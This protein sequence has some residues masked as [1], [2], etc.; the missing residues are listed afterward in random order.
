[1]KLKKLAFALLL[2]FLCFLTTSIYAQNVGI[3]STGAAPDNSAMLD[4]TSTDKG[5]L[6]P[7]MTTTQ[8]DAISNPATG[9]MIYNS[10]DNQFNFYDG[11]AWSAIGSGSGGDNLGNHTATQDVQLN[12]NWL[13]NDGGALDY[14][15]IQ[16]DTNG[17]VGIQINPAGAFQVGAGKNAE[18]L[19]VNQSNNLNANNT[20]PYWQ[21]FTAPSDFFLTR[22]DIV[23]FNGTPNFTYSLYEGEGTGGTLL[24]TGTSTTSSFTFDEIPLLA[25]QKYTINIS[26]PNFSVQIRQANVDAYS[27]GTSNAIGG[28]DLTFSVYGRTSRSGLLVS[29]TGVAFENYAFPVADGTSN[30]V[31]STNGTG[32]VSWSNQPFSNFT[33][34]G[35]D[36]TANQVLT[37]DG[38]GTIS[39]T[40]NNTSIL[41]DADQNTKIQVEK[42]SNED[43]I[44]FDLNGEEKWTMQGNRLSN[45]Q[46]NIYIGKGTGQQVTSGT[47]IIAIG[48]STLFSNTSGIGNIAVGE[49]SLFANTTG[50]FNIV[51]GEYALT[52]NTIGSNNIAM[53]SNALLNCTSGVRNVGLGR[54]AGSFLT[55]GS[56][57]TLLGYEVGRTITTGSENVMLGMNA[58]LNAGN[59]TGSTLV[60]FRAGF[61]GNTQVTAVGYQAGSSSGARGVYLGYNAGVNETGADKLYIDNSATTTPLIWGDFAND[62]LKVFGTFNINDAFNFPTTDG[63]NGQ[64][65][66]TDGAG[67]LTWTSLTSGGFQD[68]SLSGNTLSL[69][70]DP[71]TV[72]LSSFL[73]NTDQQDLS[74][75]NDTLTISNGTAKI[76]L[77]PYLAVDDLGNHIATQNIQLNDQWISNDGG[78]EGFIINND[79]EIG[80][81]R[82]VG[83]N[84]G[85]KLELYGPASSGAGPHIQAVTSTSDHPV[86]QYFNFDHDNAAILFD[87]YYNPATPSWKSSDAGS[88]FAI[89]KTVDKLINFYSAGNAPGNDLAWSTGTFLDTLGNF[90][91][92]RPLTTALTNRLEV[93][94]QAS[95]T[96]AGSWIA[97]SDARLKK[98][99]ISLSANDILEKMLSLQGVTYEWNDTQTGTKRPEG[100]QYGFTAQ[101]IQEVFPTLVTED[102]NGFLQTPY[103]TYDAMTVEAI[104]ALNDKIEQLE[105]ENAELK[106]QVAEIQ[107]LKS[108]IATLQSLVEKINLQN[109]NSLDKTSE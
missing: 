73:D 21:S 83:T 91:I 92:G 22:F 97:N 109:T 67:Q 102:N 24:A 11:T 64:V 94:G 39:W 1:M 72:D 100:I 40:N 60:G 52:S 46:P 27:G 81:G 35:S 32:T 65:L 18:A 48:D 43:I 5:M 62:S 45:S 38:A 47:E 33:L 28:T 15:G 12:G 6:V 88:N 55:T 85:A 70:G 59:V 108:S 31:L 2:L 3:N 78:N 8:R 54:L 86:T 36:G 105:Q 51:I 75:A 16:V 101:N 9:L 19:I 53:G 30:Q 77:K 80:I 4:I 57:N 103:G 90:S 50:N 76:D 37:T 87:S 69:S 95:K 106:S 41:E 74:I 63:T 96:T 58:G 17:N 14:E 25:N 13:S 49:G 61:A 89:Y 82:A 34:P 99:I 98:N 71:S 29:E 23:I 66:L 56:N 10:T 7:R 84:G 26:A 104:R 44:R 79:G 107:D 68:M 20:Y 42:N 93:E